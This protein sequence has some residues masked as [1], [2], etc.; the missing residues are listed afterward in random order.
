MTEDFDVK[1]TASY[2]MDIG[3]FVE[4]KRPGRGADHTNHLEP[5][6]KKKYSYT[7]TSH[8]DLHT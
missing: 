8:L 6:L 5:N 3:S 2:T 4:V 7:F 1:N